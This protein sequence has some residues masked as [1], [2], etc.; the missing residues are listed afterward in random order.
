VRL[1]GGP[2][3]E[4]PRRR[5][6][7]RLH[8]L[9]QGEFLASPATR[10]F[11][12]AIDRADA[13]RSTFYGHFLDTDDLLMA[14]LA[15]LEIPAPDHTTW[16]SD[17]PGFGWTLELFR[18]FDSGRRLF[19]AVASSHTSALARRET[20]RR[21]EDLARA[22]LSRLQ[23]AK[24]L[25]EF[26]R[27]MVVRF[28]VGTWMGFMWTGASEGAVVNWSCWRSRRPAPRP[29]ASRPSDAS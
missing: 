10:F 20:I 23:A 5:K 25:D 4:Q 7:V 16:R 24:R 6:P 15:D 12:D 8:G 18:H 29:P 1:A 19:R 11:Q 21:L 26:R 17:G 2:P 28:L 14:I 27:E 13:G 22:E 9:V 3:V